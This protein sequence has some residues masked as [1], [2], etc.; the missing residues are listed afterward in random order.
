M[1]GDTPLIRC[2]S[3][4]SAATIWADYRPCP[5]IKKTP[6]QTDMVFR[7]QSRGAREIVKQGKWGGQG[8]TLTVGP[9]GGQNDL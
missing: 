1:T 9:L 3:K 2:S 7:E 4:R 6:D 8:K 5:S